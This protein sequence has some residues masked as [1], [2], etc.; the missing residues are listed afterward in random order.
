MILEPSLPVSG[1]VIDVLEN[2]SF[3][4]LGKFVES[5]R[6]GVKIGKT[7]RYCTVL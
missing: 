3:L 4:K 5:D 7:I 1:Y 6:L 2:K